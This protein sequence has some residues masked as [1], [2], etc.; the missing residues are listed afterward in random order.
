MACIGVD[1][2]RQFARGGLG[3]VMGS[4]K[5]KAV[6]VDGSTKIEYFDNKK[7][8]EINKQFTKDVLD[9]DGV[10]FRREKGTMKCVRSGQ[11]SS[12]LPTKNFQKGVYDKFEDLSSETAR[13]ELNWEDTGCFNCAIR[14]SK[15]ARWDNHE[16]EGP[17]YETTA[18]LGSGCEISNIKDVTW[19]NEICNDLGLDTISTGV[20]CSFAMECFE[21]GYLDNWSNLNLVWGNAEAQREFIKLI[22]KRQ[23]V[24]EIF[25]DGTKIASE[26]IGK[27]S[28]DF[29][30]NIYGMEIS[31]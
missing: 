4:K 16:L 22:A 29:A 30:I 26:K 21:K 14:C 25:A 2:H 12:Y 18:Y 15:W 27:D 9:N 23:G 10:K 19:A 6:F 5:L 3:A 28:K 1:K 13:K 20:T 7:F 24:G 11:E 8:E 31:G 17:E